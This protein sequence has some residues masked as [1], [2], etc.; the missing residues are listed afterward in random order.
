MSDERMKILQMVAQGKISPEQGDD[1]LK[2]MEEEGDNKQ[3][4]GARWVHIRVHEPSSGDVRVNIRLPIAWA[5]KLLKFAN[6][7]A[8]DH[9]LAEIY[10]AIQSGEAGQVVQ[11]ES[12]D[13]ER[14]EIWLEE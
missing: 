10:E 12:D 5:G 9:D 2:A 1:L 3:A 6:K 7:Y 11:V 8:P 14:V 4:G 13:G